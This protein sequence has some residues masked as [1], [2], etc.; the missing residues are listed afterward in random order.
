[1]A[2]RFTYLKWLSR[3]EKL[4]MN[5]FK[6]DQFFEVVFCAYNS[7][8]QIKEIFLITPYFRKVKSIPWISLNLM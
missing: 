6:V 5:K 1:M 3:D 8:Y 2:E 7:Y 4:K